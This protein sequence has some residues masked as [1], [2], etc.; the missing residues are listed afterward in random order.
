MVIENNFPLSP[1][2]LIIFK[3]L[4]SAG[5][6]P[7]IVGGAVR[8]LLLQNLSPNPDVDV[9]LY[10]RFPVDEADALLKQVLKDRPVK[11]F[12]FKVFKLDSLNIDL[13]F[14]RIETYRSGS[15]SHHDFEVVHD[16]QMKFADAILR[17]D[18]TINAIGL[19]Y[20]N[21]LF[22]LV[23]PLNA[24]VDLKNKNLKCVSLEHFNK[25][26]VRFLRAIRFKINLSFDFDPEL[27]A[28]FKHFILSNQSKFYLFSEW[29]K[30]KDPMRFL[31]LLIGYSLK[32]SQTEI[33]KYI[34]SLTPI[35]LSL[36]KRFPRDIDFN[37]A[38]L[39][40]GAKSEI[41]FEILQKLFGHNQATYDFFKAPNYTT[42]PKGVSE[43]HFNLAQSL[44]L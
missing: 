26:P 34:S 15:V 10:S 28:Q 35:A 32:E 6:I 31:S 38:F 29:K 41:S 36:M 16:P 17:R 18:F 37:L 14:P 7:I 44:N 11:E 9:E 21:G 3:E 22:E 27:E 42:R 5:L 4:E 43:S 39:I 20:S 12:N 25:D 13:S 24:V 2:Q 33:F 8:D 23:D 40:L 19:K 30:T 1:E